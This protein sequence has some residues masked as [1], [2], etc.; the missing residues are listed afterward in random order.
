[1]IDRREPGKSSEARRSALITVRPDVA[2]D[3][4][5]QQ[6]SAPSASGALRRVQL[7]SSTIPANTAMAPTIG[8]ENQRDSSLI[9]CV[10]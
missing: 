10:S 5:G 4:D 8:N 2:A 3:A 6:S 7:M 9:R 1:M